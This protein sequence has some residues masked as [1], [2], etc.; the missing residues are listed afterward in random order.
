MTGAE[1]FRRAIEF[2]GP[3]YL[4]MRLECNLDWL[5][6]KN[7][8]KQDRIRQLQAQLPDDWMVI[9]ECPQP[10]KKPHSENGVLRWVDHWGT[11]WMDDGH[12]AKTETYPL[13]N[14]YLLAASHPFP[15]PSAPGLFDHAGTLLKERS[16]K[17][18]AA[19]VWFTLF[20]RLW[21]LRGFENMLMDPYTEPEH[22]RALMEKIL[23][24]NMVM[25]DECLRRGANGIYFSDD[26]GCQR[27]LLIHPDDWRN[28]Y[29][30]AYAQMFRK[31]RDGGAHVWMH[32]CGN[33]T[34]ILGDLID[35]GLNVL[36]PVQPQAMDLQQLARDFGGHVCFNGGVDVQGA[37]I[38]GTPEDVKRQ[39]KEL[40]HL[41][42]QFNGGYIA[43]ASHS[44]MP[45]TPLDN[46]IALYE[47]FLDFL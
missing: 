23:A 5:H 39:A 14:G 9:H 32:L 33:I 27:G 2:H 31:V 1:N 35:L 17:Y 34:A 30:P 20:E 3:D 40:V 6:E 29:K 24:Y 8:A 21:M 16:G 37:M 7:S 19:T 42:G 36:N 26:W 25:I 44:I 12:G 45:E 43:G 11:G 13:E 38:H 47:A 10:Q 41:F 15:N 22:W 28:Y 18:V 4:P 46:V